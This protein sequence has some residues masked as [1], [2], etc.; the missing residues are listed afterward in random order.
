VMLS[1]NL[2]KLTIIRAGVEYQ[3]SFDGFKNRYFNRNIYDNYTAEFL[4]ADIFLSTKLVWRAGLRNEY[5]TLLKRLRLAPRTSLSY[6]LGEFR[7]VSV[8]YGQF[9][10]KPDRDYL[11]YP[12]IP[13]YN[14]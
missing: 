14:R 9:Y 4:E 1:R 10:Q 11:F 5:S 8:A 2:G 12:T 3:Y 13:G 7:Q 6:K